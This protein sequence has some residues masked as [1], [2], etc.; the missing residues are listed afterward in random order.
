[1]VQT[2]RLQRVGTLSPGAREV[3]RT[4]KVSG[5]DTLSGWMQLFS[6][7]ASYDTTTD[8][9]QE[10]A[11]KR[12]RLLIVV[13][14]ALLFVG[15]VVVGN[16]TTSPIAWAVLWLL[17]LASGAGAVVLHRR[18]RVIAR[19]DLCNDFRDSLLP[20]LDQI[21]EDVSPKAKV[22]VALD[23]VGIGEGKRVRGGG[24]GE[25]VYAD[26]WCALDFKLVDGSAISL[27]IET[28][29]RKRERRNPRGKLKTKWKK[30]V[31]VSA[32]LAPGAGTVIDRD[33]GRVAPQRQFRFKE[34][35]GA[36]IACLREQ[37][38]FRSQGASFP[39]DTAAY[40]ADIIGVLIG[41]LA[42]R[43]PAQKGA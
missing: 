14:V 8:A 18:G 17:V 20:F 33:R 28:T 11:K 7:L 29:C 35:G 10:G 36:T 13:C 16:T 3:V 23:L 6:E 43:V 19:E 25:T 39:T 32:A 15:S 42:L 30:T 26:P 1:M 34:K 4:R 27:R 41:V 9:L 40:A 22:T 38:V 31:E 21:A 12:S 24:N 2:P 37:F 5:S